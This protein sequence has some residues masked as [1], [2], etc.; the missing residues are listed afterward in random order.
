MESSPQQNH[1]FLNLEISI[2]LQAVALVSAILCVLL[3]STSDSL[4]TTE[5]FLSVLH[6]ACISGKP[7]SAASMK[8]LGPVLEIGFFG[9]L[10]C[11]VVDSKYQIFLLR[12]IFHSERLPLAST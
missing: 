10:H 11:S 12:S 4:M 9:S 3:V 2:A 6:S 7:L 1:D 5:F 8:H